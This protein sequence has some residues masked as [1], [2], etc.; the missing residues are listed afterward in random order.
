M[1]RYIVIAGMNLLVA[2]AIAGNAAYALLRGCNMDGTCAGPSSAFTW[3]LAFGLGSLCIAG[4]VVL[5][6]YARRSQHIGRARIAFVGTR[7]S[8]DGEAAA[9]IGEEA[10]LSRLARLSRAD[11]PAQEAVAAQPPIEPV[12][13][14]SGPDLHLV[15]SDGERM[16]PPPAQSHASTPG[17]EPVSRISWLIDC[18][19][20]NAARVRQDTGFPWSVAGIDRAVQGLARFDEFLLDT[21]VPSECAAWRSLAGAMCRDHALS[22]EDARAFTNWYNASLRLVGRGGVAMLNEAMNGLAA[23]AAHDPAIARSL[24]AAFWHAGAGPRLLALSA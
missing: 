13:A 24:P 7:G 11:E 15:A 5:T 19:V 4:I 10:M 2:A 8:L 18:G 3:A 23:E 16:P 21:D 9:S 12:A 1:N 6:R 22:E 17:A 20:R 14:P